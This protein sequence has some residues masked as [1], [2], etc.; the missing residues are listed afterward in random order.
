MCP[1]RPFS[2]NRS[3]FDVLALAT[4]QLRV[5]DHRLE[6]ISVVKGEFMG[7]IGVLRR[8]LGKAGVPM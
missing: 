8:Y 4:K 6:H 7:R 3:T 1:D 2:P 5:G